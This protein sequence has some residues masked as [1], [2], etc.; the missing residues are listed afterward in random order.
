MLCEALSHS[1]SVSFQTLTIRSWIRCI[2][3]MYLK[4]LYEPDD[5]L[6]DMNPEQAVGK[7]CR[8]FAFWITKYV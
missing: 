7:Y 6:I 8:H 5:L 2:L 3:Q 4:N 1:G